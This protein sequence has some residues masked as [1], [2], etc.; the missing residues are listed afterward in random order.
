MILCASSP[1]LAIPSLDLTTHSGRKAMARRIRFFLLFLTGCVICVGCLD[2]EFDTIVERQPPPPGKPEDEL[3]DDSLEDKA[4]IAFDA[5][6][7]DRR[8]LGEL[9]LNASSAVLKLSVPG[10]KPQED[11][12]LQVLR[13]SY[14][15]AV[16][17]ARAK[18]RDETILPSVNLLDSKA[19]QFD[20]GLYAALDQA[21]YHG[22][23]DRLKSHVDLVRRIYAIVGKDSVAAPYLAAGL[24]LAGVQ[25]E[26]A[27]TAAKEEWL[28]DFRK[29][30]IASKPI[31]FYTWDKDL[32]KCFR[33][34]RFFQHEF[35]ASQLNV[36][37]ALRDAVHSDAVLEEDYRRALHFYAKLS[38]SA[39]GSCVLNFPDNL[40]PARP[41]EHPTVALFPSSTSR[42]TVLFEKLFPL[43]LPESAQ[44]MDELIRAIRSGKIDLKPDPNSGWYDY[45]VY[46][47][48]TLLLPEKGEEHDKLVLTKEYKKRMMEAFKA[49]I[50]KRRETHV[51]QMANPFVLGMEAPAIVQVKTSPRLRVEPCP[52]YYLRTARAY[53]F[54]ANFLEANIG[55]EA[56]KTLH[57]LRQGGQRELNLD[58]ELLRMRDLFYGLYLVSAED[59]GL[60]PALTKEE[61]PDCER[62]YK[63]AAEWLPKAFADPDL[64]IDTRVCVPIFPDRSRG[65]TRIWA[66]LGV[67][68][69]HLDAEY[70][71]PPSVAQAPRPDAD[72][73]ER[74][75]W[76][77]LRMDELEASHYLIAV[78]E[79][80]EV[81]LPVMHALSREDLRAVCDR[82]KTKDAII[83]ALRNWK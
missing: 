79:F 7:V 31:G 39:L 22:L 69:A 13:P 80:A 46:A 27:D 9:L 50:T 67:R 55:K 62:C 5:K 61:E 73:K 41:G 45:Q 47:L 12:D 71:R 78:D 25:V 81:E 37:R 65:V 19:K 58:A 63:L 75:A 33:F 66:T 76:R 51:R 15:A 60:R 8:P 59:I 82:E 64:A 2:L 44:L 42:E 77:E 3:K 38:N 14:A 1:I 34:L 10:A 53:A 70:L 74:A 43:G 49:L 40:G 18:H 28:A 56:L 6:L 72:P 32:E 57:G 21:Y 24:E 68:L 30:K 48:E 20:D 11:D 54:L 26:P 35:T 52:S 29:D 16:S 83:A 17:A 36:P 23:Y 4:A